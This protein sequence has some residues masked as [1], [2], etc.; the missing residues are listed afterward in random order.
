VET[1]Y[2]KENGTAGKKGNLLMSRYMPVYFY[3]DQMPVDISFVFE[4]EKPAGKHGFCQVKGDQFAFED[5]TP[6]KF[7]GVIF[8]GACCFPKHDYAEGVAERLAQ[9][10][11]NI[12]R[13][14]QM[15]AEWATPNIFRLTA[16]KCLVDTRHFDPRCM[17]RMDYLIKCLKDQGIYIT[18]DVTTYRKFKSGD[19]VVDADLLT[20]NMKGV[21]LYDPKMIELQKEY[22]Y[23]F[24]NHVNPYTGL[25]YKDDPVFVMVDITNEN[26]MFVHQPNHKLYSVRS[27]YYDD[28]FRDMFATWLKEQNIDYDAYGCELYN[29]DQPMVDFRV[30]L[31]KKFYE[32]MRNY[33]RDEVG[34]KIPITGTNWSIRGGLVKSQENMDFQD[35]HR[36]FYDWRWGENEKATFNRHL[37]EE[38]VSCLGGACSTRIHGQP[39]FMTE[40]DMPWPNSYRAEAPIWFPAIAC[41]Q[42]WSGMTI[43]TYAY[44]TKLSERDLLGK[45]S[46]SS[47]IGSVPYREGIFTCWNDPSKFGLFYHGALMIRRGDIQ[48]AKKTIGAK[49]TDYGHN[50]LNLTATA[51]EVHRVDSVLDTTDTSD[52][53]DIRPIEENFE[54]DPNLIV[55]D[56]GEVWRDVAKRMGAVDTPRTKAVYGMLSTNNASTLRKDMEVK[57]NGMVVDCYTDFA[58]IALSSL[59]DDPI[60]HSHNMLLSTIGRSHSR[61]AL[62]DGEKLLDF[63]T[64]PIEVE[65]IDA[66]ISIKTDVPRLRVWSVNSEGYYVGRIPVEYED[67]WIRFHVGPEYPG[68]YYLIMQE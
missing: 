51:M 16:G 40:W 21:A 67:G 35:G 33:L 9:A 58:T 49:I 66:V 61:G 12:V 14:H 13:F 17:E 20:D 1:F 62:F 53:T 22:A 63:G 19:G 42:G 46:S 2:N 6:A 11:C 43:H 39:F 47:T 56:T 50:P 8:N 65:V 29:T 5:G 36:Y 60:E 26:D 55:S 24:W 57:L 68:M 30:H 4:N 7:W 59:T 28:M 52:L 15:D 32:E 38:P 41:L 18:T 48:Q 64:G 27:K 10:G 54:R 25:A 44:G 31:G 45:E 23:N 3:P 37:T 34:V